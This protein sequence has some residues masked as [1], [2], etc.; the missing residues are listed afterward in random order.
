MEDYDLVNTKTTT[1]LKYEFSNMLKVKKKETTTKLLT[2][3]YHSS[4]VSFFR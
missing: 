4:F 2:L 1:L 3:V